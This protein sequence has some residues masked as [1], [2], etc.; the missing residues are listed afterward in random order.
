MSTELSAEILN[1]IIMLISAILFIPLPFIVAYFFKKYFNIIREDK[2]KNK[3]AFFWEGI[4]ENDYLSML[5][6][7]YLVM[8]KLFFIF[9]LVVFNKHTIVQLVFSSIPTISLGV[10]VFVKKPFVNKYENNI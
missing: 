6:N 4:R 10:F 2:N 8:R 7:V 1:I 9:S 5:Y 3:F